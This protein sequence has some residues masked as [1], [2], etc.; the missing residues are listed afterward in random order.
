PTQKCYVRKLLRAKN[1]TRR[2]PSFRRFLAKRHGRWYRRDRSFHS[3]IR[4]SAFKLFRFGARELIHP[5][6]LHVTVMAPHPVPS[7]L[8]AAL[9]FVQGLPKVRVLH[10]FLVRGFPAFAL[11]AVDP[12]R[13]AFL[14]V[15][16][17]G[18]YADAARTL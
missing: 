8:M 3:A 18:G 15:L 11:P 7:H 14:D 2:R 13:D 12:F 16:A 4:R 6:V 10:R 9:R 17:V 5:L 1:I